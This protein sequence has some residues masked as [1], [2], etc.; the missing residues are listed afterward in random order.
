MNI[1]VFGREGDRCVLFLHAACTAWDFYEESIRLL[2]RRFRVVVPALPG[3][4]LTTDE[5]YTS[6]ERIAEELERWLLARGRSRVHGLYGLSMG[7]SVA[8]R[9]LGSGKIRLTGS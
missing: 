5:D 2:S 4:D 9:L 7:G 6:V 8:L 3:H 1:H